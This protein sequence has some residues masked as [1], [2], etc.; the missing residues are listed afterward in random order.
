MGRKTAN[1]AGLA[2]LAGVA[3]ANRDKLGFG[4]KEG[5]N[6]PARPES[7]ETRGMSDEDKAQLARES[8]RGPIGSTPTSEMNPKPIIRRNKPAPEPVVTSDRNENYGNE[9]RAAV[10][11]SSSAPPVYMSKT[12]GGDEKRTEGSKPMPSLKAVETRIASNKTDAMRNASRANVA[13]AN[14]QKAMRA[15]PEAQ[16][17]EAVYPEQYLTPGG[18]FKTAANMAKNLANRGGREVAEYSTPLLR[19]AATEVEAARAAAPRL[20]GPTPQLTGPSKAE[21]VA[22]DRAARAAAREE[23]MRAEN[24]A[25]YGLNPQ[26]PGYSASAGALRDKLGGADFSLGMKRGGAV[27]AKRMA[28]GGMTSKMPSASRRGDGIAS[29]GKTRGKIC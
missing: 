22:R 6:R 13:G 7:V 16:A 8:N 4:N 11:Q 1:L 19:N 28:S 26:A 21:L 5:S 14:R 2:A 29:R 12:P 20:G 17:A 15:N 10:P 9:G 25:N 3:Y 18:G 24:A 27:K 23:G